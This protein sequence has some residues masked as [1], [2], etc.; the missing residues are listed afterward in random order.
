[1]KKSELLIL[2]N[3]ASYGELNIRDIEL[4]AQAL[5]SGKETI[6]NL[7]SFPTPKNKV[8]VVIDGTDL[9]FTIE[10]SIFDKG[11]LSVLKAVA[12]KLGYKYNYSQDDNGKMIMVISGAVK[13]RGRKKLDDEE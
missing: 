10:P 5:R 3:E 12:E 13:K 4:L 1:M 2:I 9:I 7:H 6:I 8:R 11:V